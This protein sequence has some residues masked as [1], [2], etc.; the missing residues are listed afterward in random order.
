M[1]YHDNYDDER[2]DLI[3][4]TVLKIVL[5]ISIL[6]ILLNIAIFF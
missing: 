2:A 5:V 3:I 1:K 6:S 4:T